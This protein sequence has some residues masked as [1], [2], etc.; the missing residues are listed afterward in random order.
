[1]MTKRQLLILKLTTDPTETNLTISLKLNCSERTV[2][3]DQKKIKAFLNVRNKEEL[4]L[5]LAD[6][7]GENIQASLAD[8]TAA[9]DPFYSPSDDNQIKLHC[10]IAA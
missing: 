9:N 6:P 10:D 3:E 7:T 1:M 4:L 8:L 5:K 2:L